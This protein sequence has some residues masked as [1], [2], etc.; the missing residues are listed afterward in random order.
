MMSPKSTSVVRRGLLSTA[1][2]GSVRRPIQTLLIAAAIVP[3]FLIALT[4]ATAAG[5]QP[6]I[7]PATSW[8]FN[9]A[10]VLKT[11]GTRE[12]HFI[13][14]YG[15]YWGRPWDDVLKQ[16]GLRGEIARGVLSSEIFDPA[17]RAAK[18][19][20]A[21]LYEL[22]R[23]RYKPNQWP[24]ITWALGSIW[25][26]AYGRGDPV[27]KL[28]ELNAA[29]LEH[30][31]KE[32]GDLWLGAWLGENA[33]RTAMMILYDGRQRL[34]GKANK[35]MRFTAN[36]EEAFP[37]IYNPKKQWTKRELF[38]LVEMANA[39]QSRFI[40]GYVATGAGPLMQP[41]AESEKC[42]SVMQKNPTP[43]ANA[44]GRGAARCTG[45]F[46]GIFCHHIHLGYSP[47][48]M[49]R[50]NLQY[51]IPRLK[52]HFL[53]G[54]FSGCGL[55]EVERVPCSFFHDHEGDGHWE[56][57]ELGKMFRVLFD[58]RRRH[59]HRG[60]PYTPVALMEDWYTCRYFGRTGLSGMTYRYF[61][62]YTAEDHLAY[63]LIHQ[64]LLPLPRQLRE[65]CGDSKGT[66]NVAE[67]V[68]TPYGEIFDIIRPNSPKGSPPLKVLSNYR[69]LVTVDEVQ[70][71]RAHV[72]RLMEYVRNGGVLVINTRQLTPDFTT[73]FIGVK[74]TGRT[75][76]SDQAICQLDEQRFSGKT[77][78]AD[79]VEL[80]GAET[81]VETPRRKALATRRQFGKGQVILT[82]AHFMLA[83]KAEPVF[84][85]REH[86][87][88]R[89][90]AC[91][92]PHL[93][94]HLL[95]GLVPIEVRTSDSGNLRYSFL[96]KGEGWVV[97]LM[98][99]RHDKEYVVRN[100]ASNWFVDEGYEPRMIPVEIVCRV[101]VGD[102]L[103][104][105][106]DRDV[107]CSKN[108]DETIV[109]LSVPAGEVR[110]VELQPERIDLGTE[111]VPINLAYRKEA[112]AS[113]HA[114][115]YE[116]RLAVDGRITQSKG[117][118][119]RMGRNKY[120]YPLP[121][122]LEV[123]L[124]DVKPVQS[125]AIW[126]AW[127]SLPSMKCRFYRYVIEGSADRETWTP[128]VDESQNVNPATEEGEQ[129]WF[130]PLDIRYVRVRVLHSSLGE[131][132][133]I[134]ELKVFGN[135]TTTRPR[136]R[137]PAEPG[138]IVFPIDLNS[139][140][141]DKVV[142]LA[143][144]K[145][146]SCQLGWGVFEDWVGR[147]LGLGSPKRMKVLRYEKCVFAQT[148]STIVYRLGGKYTH[149]LAVAGL[150]QPRPVSSATFEVQVDGETKMKSD[151]VV[152]DTY[153]FAVCVDVRGANEL[154]LITDDAGDGIINDCAIWGAARLIR[155]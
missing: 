34:A 10:W 50:F 79:E 75:F 2:H 91:F 80:A 29:A 78:V 81:I 1:R 142:Y 149:F 109:R 140:D 114:K 143:D 44:V 119:S 116:P 68:D 52:R 145:P 61:I 11:K 99:N 133:M 151:L 98:S 39:E 12:C 58:L 96:R 94:D 135:E 125:V 88:F 83:K 19:H 127:S 129:R 60:V 25:K 14:H 30:L 13:T 41:Q 85:G 54:Y 113:S 35:G 128:M 18:P 48:S 71:E 148:D 132:A 152:E 7:P 122:W 72:Q 45:K 126:F 15:T 138:K 31:R 6:L 150:H 3:L 154:K 64:Q 56:L 155:R 153:P 89:P 17:T 70:W 111:T 59:R 5:A 147:T 40:G 22:W 134:S 4:S 49:R 101:K 120:D 87:E 144:M 20:L 76:E 46:W 38:R 74:L 124:G 115:G 55:L 24:F 66:Y 53:G 65:Q 26:T 106:E 102:A 84:T 112:T 105:M 69:I 130:D 47:L 37:D 93:M 51:S 28:D 16:H 90:L 77:Y 103:E 86:L 136:K 141:K 123:D 23:T 73:D 110:A 42:L 108:K 146:E 97:V 107:Q 95:E 62:P 27:P 137:K 57:S 63:R 100:M 67:G 121:H 104:W 139:I 21:E 118:W 131:G 36:I 8:D 82:T 92:V 43:T 32:A 9:D 117:W 33:E